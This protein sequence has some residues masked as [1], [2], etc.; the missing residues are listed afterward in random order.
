M[1]RIH[2]FELEDQSWFPKPIRNGITDFLQFAVS[3]SDLY[4]PFAARLGRV[5]DASRV[6]RIVDLCAGAGGPWLELKEHVGGIRSGAVSV[7]LTDFYPNHTAFERLK[8]AWQDTFSFVA[9]PVSA[10]DVP[11]ELVGFRTLFSAFHHFRPEEAIKIL[12]DAV[13]KQQGIAIA[14]STQRHPLLIAYMF[15]TPLLVLLSSVF[16]KPFRWSRLFWTYVIPV[17][18]LAVL[19]DGIVSCLRTYT[20]EELMALVARVP[21]SESF[22]WEAGIDR[23]GPL[24]VG[25]TYLIGYPRVGNI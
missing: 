3:V 19:F 11:T 12:E 25:V 10:I 13:S 20:P 15:L 23:I 22:H 5:L 21:G 4:K 6:E 7:C 8:S 2:F 14:E 17:V 18:P 16:Q 1:P 24:P 9:E